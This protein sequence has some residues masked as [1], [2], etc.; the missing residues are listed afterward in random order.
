MHPSA[1]VAGNDALLTGERA[2][3]RGPV[4]MECGDEQA[5]FE[6]PHL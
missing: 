4:A 2:A 3:T 5:G 6:V 1:E